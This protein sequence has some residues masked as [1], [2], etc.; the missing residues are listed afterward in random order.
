MAHGDFAATVTREEADEIIELMCEI[1]DE[2]YQQPARLA[3]RKAARL[4]VK[5][6]SESH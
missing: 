6:S 4:A 1:L 2:V 5:G 3:K